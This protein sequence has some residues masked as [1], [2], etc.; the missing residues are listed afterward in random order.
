MSERD[1]DGAILRFLCERAEERLEQVQAADEIA[2]RSFQGP[3]GS[4]H[5]AKQDEPAAPD[6]PR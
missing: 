5:W 6:Q 2:H 1:V 3:D 4:Y